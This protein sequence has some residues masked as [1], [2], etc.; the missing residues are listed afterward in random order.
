MEEQIGA[1]IN[2]QALDAKIFELRRQKEA[3]PQE[4]VELRE[5]YKEKE[6][7]LESY[8]NEIKQLQLERKNKEIDHFI[9]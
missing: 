3:K 7:L 5:S 2:L 9:I 8:E 6:K 1:L 4:I